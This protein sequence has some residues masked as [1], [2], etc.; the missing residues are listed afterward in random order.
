MENRRRRRLRTRRDPRASR[1]AEVEK[2]G[3]SGKHEPPAPPSA[4]PLSSTHHG[5]TDLR[6]LQK[7]EFQKET[8]KKEMTGRTGPKVALQRGPFIPRPKHTTE[9]DISPCL[10]VDPPPDPRHF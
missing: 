5:K 10:H 4:S 2:K 6:S 1:N 3:H 8:P 9:R 7:E